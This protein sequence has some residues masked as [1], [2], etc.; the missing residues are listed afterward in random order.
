MPEPQK[1][2]RI[3]GIHVPLAE[4]R[5]WFPHTK[6]GSMRK[7]QLQ[8]WIES[9]AV[10][11]QEAPDTGILY[12]PLSM[13][14]QSGGLSLHTMR[15]LWD[16]HLL[17]TKKPRMEDRFQ[18]FTTPMQRAVCDIVLN[19]AYVGLFGIQLVTGFIS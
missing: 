8:A 13:I 5:L 18:A 14:E 9:F 6:V 11:V 3:T 4:S 1:L 19:Q 16:L 17:F 7:D 12:I 10:R 15:R 2:D